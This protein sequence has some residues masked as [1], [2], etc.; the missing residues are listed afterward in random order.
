[1]GGGRNYGRVEIFGHGVWGTVCD[2][3]W[4][5]NGKTLTLPI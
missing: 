4:D 2:D 1:M 3:S 5:M